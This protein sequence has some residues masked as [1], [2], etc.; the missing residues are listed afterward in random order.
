VRHRPALQEPVALEH[1]PGH[2][3]QGSMFGVV[4]NGEADAQVEGRQQRKRSDEGGGVLC[5]RRQP[6]DSVYYLDSRLW[7]SVARCG[8][9]NV[10]NSNLRPIT[11]RARVS[12]AARCAL[13]QVCGRD[14]GEY[15]M[16]KNQ[17]V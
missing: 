15:I 7:S 14:A 4:W 10:V 5:E 13:K 8:G 12:P 11:A 3:H 6:A 2:D 1:G 16:R 17:G 9:G